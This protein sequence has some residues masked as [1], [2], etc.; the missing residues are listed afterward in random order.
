MAMMV[1]IENE[2]NTVLRWWAWKFWSKLDV[3]VIFQFSLNIPNFCSVN[4][5]WNFRNFGNFINSPRSC[6]ELNRPEGRIS[7]DEKT[8][9]HHLTM[10][11]MLKTRSTKWM[12]VLSMLHVGIFSS[13]KSIF[14]LLHN[15]LKIA[16][17]ASNISHWRT[18][19]TSE[20]GGGKMRQDVV[21]N[22]HTTTFL[23]PPECVFGAWKQ[24]LRW[25]HWESHKRRRQG[26]SLAINFETF[27]PFFFLSPLF[28]LLLLTPA[29]LLWVGKWRKKWRN[30]VGFSMES[31]WRLKESWCK[32]A[33]VYLMN[34]NESD[35]KPTDARLSRLLS[36][37]RHSHLARLARN[38]SRCFQDGFFLKAFVVCK[39]FEETFSALF[40]SVEP[41]LGFI[42]WKIEALW[43][44]WVAGEFMKSANGQKND[45]KN[46]FYDV[47]LA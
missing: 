37:Q 5:I 22:E 1:K 45:R 10:A 11:E 3:S 40:H 26:N 23:I 6:L 29:S 32:V 2:L 13:S 35:T 47:P 16:K 17:R 28:F 4:W 9:K 36:C 15:N 18:T 21:L 8:L 46:I 12:N 43:D 38:S 39:I 14:L 42:S 20:T 44:Q 27:S 30:F 25:G 31:I 41:H 7:C 34:L 19:S 24:L 33:P